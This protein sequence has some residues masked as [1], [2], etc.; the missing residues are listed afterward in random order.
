MAYDKIWQEQ[1]FGE[2][3]N[4]EKRS[5]EGSL[6]GKKEKKAQKV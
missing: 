3:L 5:P 4:A 6:N 2:G 1:T